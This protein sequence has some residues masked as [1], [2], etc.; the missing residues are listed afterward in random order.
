M[1]RNK[2]M[3]IKCSMAL[4]LV[5]GAVLL[6][7]ASV[8]AASD[9]SRIES[10]AKESYTFKTYLN[11]DRIHVKS[12]DGVVTLTGT[13]A[14]DSH[15]SLAADTVANLP[16]VVSVNNEL[17]VRGAQV[18]EKSDSWLAFKVKS[19]LLFHKNVSAADT[20]VDAHDGAITLTGTAKS[21]S[22]KDLT[23]EL[24]RD[25][26]GVRSVNNQIVVANNTANTPGAP[27]VESAG[28]Q[29]NPH[30]TVGQQI[31]DASITAQVKSALL[32]HNSTSA[33]NTKVKTQAGV[34]TVSGVAKDGAEKDLVSH[35]VSDINGVSSVDN[36]MTVES[37]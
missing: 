9:D 5:T 20:K 3:K 10:A 22:Q 24:T 36:E 26:E 13:V 1:E 16:G 25:I 27:V 32:S 11:S 31:D 28:A 14:D 6:S 7:N 19:E 37:Q 23:A 2:N 33:V 30:E 8:Q 35:L 15:R 21:D 4:A 12:K 18:D 29:N 17:R 34:V